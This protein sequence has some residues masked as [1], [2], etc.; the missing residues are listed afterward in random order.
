MV[1]SRIRI[2]SMWCGS[3]TL[4]LRDHMDD[5][6]LQDFP[7]WPTAGFH[8]LEHEDELPFNQLRN[9]VS[10]NI[11]FIT[12]LK[13]VFTGDLAPKCLYSTSTIFK[14]SV[15]YRVLVGLQ[16]G[17][18]IWSRMDLHSFLFLEP[19][20]KWD[21]DPGVKPANSIFKRSIHTSSRIFF[22]IFFKFCFLWLEDD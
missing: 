22:V 13:I 18:R 17:F 6:A 11:Y 4:L 8:L 5:S 3:K 9:Q 10:Y 12:N 20:S 14:N 7:P 15:A 16:K 19:H 21:T 1:I 2:P